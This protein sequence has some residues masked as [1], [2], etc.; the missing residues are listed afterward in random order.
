MR[1]EYNDGLKVNYSGSLQIMKGKDVNVFMK[2]GFIPVNIKRDLE[3]AARNN[4]CGEMR[5]IAK[6]VTDTVGNKACIHE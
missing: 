5:N 6:V 1:C 2:E 3:L 4:S